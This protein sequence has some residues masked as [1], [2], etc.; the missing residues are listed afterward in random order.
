MV[1]FT[2]LVAN[3]TVGPQ[4]LM[5][6]KPV[7][8]DFHLKDCRIEYVQST[9]KK[10]DRRGEE[11]VVG[12][13]E[14]HKKL[15]TFKEGDVLITDNEACF[16]TDLVTDM[17]EEMGIEKLNF[18]T[19]L[20]HLC[21]PCDNEFHADQKNRYYSLVA[22]LNSSTMNLQ[23]KCEAIHSTYYSVGEASIRN[24]FLR[25]GIL[26]NESAEAI[27]TKLLGQGIYPSTKFYKIHKEQL[28]A[29][30]YWALQHS[31]YDSS[32]SSVD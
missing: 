30:A 28:E 21:D 13:L 15:K 11:G 18:P 3:G 17:L 8:I 7:A 26:S 27:A 29:H 23:T 25:C 10:S 14:Y 1:Q 5:I 16:D 2:L 31:F 6:R 32:E 9:K 12:F 20:G 22:G 24:Y 19:G 4:F